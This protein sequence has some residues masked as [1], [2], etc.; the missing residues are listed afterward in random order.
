MFGLAD[1]DD[2]EGSRHIYADLGIQASSE[3][4]PRYFYQELY[5]V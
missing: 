3:F 2:V 4:G 1:P 5:M